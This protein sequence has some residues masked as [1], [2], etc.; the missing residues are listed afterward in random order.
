MKIFI[1]NV[2]VEFQGDRI[3]DVYRSEERADEY[4]KMLNEQ[5]KRSDCFEVI[6]YEI[7]E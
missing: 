3:V 2:S 1:I 4:C 6:E 7:V 5:S